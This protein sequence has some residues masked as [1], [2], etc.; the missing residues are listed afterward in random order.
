MT[1]KLVAFHFSLRALRENLLHKVR[2]VRSSVALSCD[3][4]I[5]GSFRRKCFEK[6]FQKA[7]EVV[8]GLS[9]CVTR[10]TG[11]GGAEAGTQRLINIDDV[12]V[13]RP[14]PLVECEI[15]IGKRLAF[16]V[17][18]WPVLEKIAKHARASVRRIPC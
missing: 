13:L 12:S 1:S 15:D 7:V 4:Q 5:L 6:P 14:S 18:N 9:E 3:V 17:A 16:H 10:A 8:S 11:F 2:D